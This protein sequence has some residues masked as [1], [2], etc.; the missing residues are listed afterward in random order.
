MIAS[1]SFRNILNNIGPNAETS[2]T[3][4]NKICKEVKSLQI[5]TFSYIY[6]YIYIYIC[7]YVCVYIYIERD[8]QIDRQTDR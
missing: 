7:I 4:D 6:I 1:K 8:R 5:C 2:E 3:P